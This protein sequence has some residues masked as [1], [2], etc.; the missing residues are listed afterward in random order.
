MLKKSD[1]DFYLPPSLIAQYPNKK[2]EFSRLLIVDKKKDNFINSHFYD[3]DK[4]LNKGDVLVFNKT[5]VFPARIFGRK[6]TGGKVE[7]F[8]LKKITDSLWEILCKG[9]NIFKK[10]I[11]ISDKMSAVIFKENSGKIFANFS[12]NGK[13][14]EKEILRIGKIPLPPYIKRDV[15]KFDEEYYQTVFGKNSGS[16]AAS[17]AGLHFSW[18]MIKRMK[19]KGIKI[20]YITLH[21]GFGTFEKL[22]Y[23]NIP[24]NTLHLE[25]C[26]IE[27]SVAK[28]IN[29]AKK[30]GF[31]VVAV[32]TTVARTLESFA[33]FESVSFGKKWTDIFLFPGKKFKIVDAL[34]T[35]FHLPK[36]SLIVMT[37]AFAGYTKIKKAYKYAIDKGYKFYSYG[38]G[39]LII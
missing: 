12:Y 24:E 14:I 1:Y 20:C 37:S 32:G 31:R 10:E 2:R 39:M 21:I 34:V 26:Q 9:S 11:I 36:S 4:F 38:D 27:E 13:N 25:Y 7:I 30:S 18:E 35:N 29:E 6:K 3:L 8:L 16:V 19:E 23:E 33:S 17:T 28:K 15:E 22:K 5:K